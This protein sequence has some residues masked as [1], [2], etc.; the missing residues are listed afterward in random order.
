MKHPSRMLFLRSVR[1]EK[2]EYD[3]K[4]RSRLEVDKFEQ[5]R[6][7]YTH[8]IAQATLASS[9]KEMSLKKM[10]TAAGTSDRMLMHYFKDK[11]DIE[12]AVLTAI[13]RELIELLQ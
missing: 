9:I 8:R 2:N 3:G 7:D 13:S 10:A 4:G 5:K 11:Q 6:Q 12:T 1:L